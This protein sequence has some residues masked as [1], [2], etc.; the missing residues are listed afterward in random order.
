[1]AES[2]LKIKTSFLTKILRNKSSLILSNNPSELRLIM[3]I[4][5][6]PSGIWFLCKETRLHDLLV[7]GAYNACLTASCKWDDCMDIWIYLGSQVKRSVDTSI[8]VSKAVRVLDF[9]RWCMRWKILEAEG[10]RK[11]GI[12]KLGPLVR[13]ECLGRYRKLP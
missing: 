13:R 12:S 2:I 10:N 11:E 4:H 7:V 1:M 9:H 3:K 5:L 8:V 6:Y